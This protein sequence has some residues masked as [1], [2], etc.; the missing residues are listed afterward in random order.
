MAKQAPLETQRSAFL[1][2]GLSG[3]L[4]TLL[5]PAIF[6]L[7]YPIGP[8]LALI[9]AEA[10]VHSVRFLT[11]RTLVFPPHKG[12]RV[13]PVRYLISVVPTTLTGFAV[14]ALLREQLSRTELTITGAIISLLIGFIWSRY[15]YSKP[16]ARL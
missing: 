3:I 6:W 1:R 14:V 7:A 4:F 10:G 12:Y 13:S 11:F 9:I 2:F 16:V 5:G 8:M 15:V